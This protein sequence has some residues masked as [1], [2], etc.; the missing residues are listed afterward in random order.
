MYF[1]YDNDTFKCKL[2][3]SNNKKIDKM[4]KLFLIKLP[5]VFDTH[6]SNMAKANTAPYMVFKITF[7]E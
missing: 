7:S 2:E 1:P 5:Q 3:E 4:T 6:N